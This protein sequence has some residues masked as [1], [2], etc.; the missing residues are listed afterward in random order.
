MTLD[1]RYP[2]NWQ[3]AELIGYVMKL[4]ILI[5]F[6]QC[7][8]YVAAVFENSSYHQE[9]YNLHPYGSVRLTSPP[10]NYSHDD[11]GFA[12]YRPHKAALLRTCRQIHTDAAHIL[13]QST[14]FTAPV[15]DLLPVF[16]ARLGP[17]YFNKICHLRIGF[18]VILESCYSCDRPAKHSQGRPSVPPSLAERTHGH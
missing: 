5:F 3:C 13:Y 12:D 15:A 6:I 17:L 18:L 4:A 7:Y 8:N 9:Q 11:S 10:L 1:V 14:T 16:A 2:Q